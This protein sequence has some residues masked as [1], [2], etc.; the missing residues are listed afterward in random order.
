MHVPHLL[1]SKDV[2]HKTCRRFISLC[3]IRLWQLK[4]ATQEK[5]NSKVKAWLKNSPFTI[6]HS[7]N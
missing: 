7:P 6:D 4:S 2:G 3:S 1:L 5:L